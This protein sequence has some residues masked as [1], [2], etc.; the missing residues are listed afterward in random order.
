MIHRLRFLWM[1]LRRPSWDSGI[2]PP[3]LM[4][5]IQTHPAGR[6]IDLGCGTG[7]NVL[8]LAQNG[9]QVTGVDFI[10]KAI[11]AA[12][13]KTQNVK[14]DLRV[15]D[16][17][18][19][20]GVRGINGPF[21][22]ALDIGC[23]HGLENKSK[24]LDELDRLLAP[25]GH[26]LLYGFFKPDSQLSGRFDAAQRKPGLDATSVDLIH[27]RGFSLL[28]RSDGFDKKNRPSAWFLF[29]KK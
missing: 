4:Q 15:G 24:Y 25:S 2:A 21:D 7:T 10:P 20:S 27:A 3:E 13:R 22:L 6:A 26:W 19:L 1:Y 9:W 23:F 5:Y 17:T 14:V 16:V 18:H 8:T 11:R 28:S 29:Q 12:K